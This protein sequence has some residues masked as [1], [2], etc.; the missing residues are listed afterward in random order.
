[1]RGRMRAGP[2]YAPPVEVGG[3]MVGGGVGEVV[4]S[5]NDR[6]K[7]GDVV[8]YA[9]FGWQE[10]AVA[11]GRDV[12][13]LD[14]ALAPVSTA[15]GVLGMPGFTAYFGLLDVGQ[16]RPGD[17]VVVSGAAGAVGSIVGQ[18]AKLLGCQVVGVAG[19]DEK[20]S[21]LTGELGFDV[22]FNYK[23]VTDYSDELKARCPAGIDVYFD[24]VGG[25]LT[26]AVMMQL[27]LRARVVICGQVASYNAT[28]VPEGPRI[29]WNLISKRA[30]IEG[31]LV[32]D[33]AARYPEAY[34]RLS[35]WVADGKIRY[36]ETVIEGFENMPDAFISMMR[37]A[38]LGKMLVRV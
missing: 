36:R 15:L 25:P 22:A 38:N 33:Y 34:A 35:R 29:L 4:A 21:W 12:R 3:L 24:N 28:E 37:G 14:P 5:E 20:V 27:A 17:C 11:S 19:S 31:F 23:Q 13:R 9:G 32:F 30:R 16:P 6:L 7:I 8:D 1:M 10:Y 18:I 26:D 2:S